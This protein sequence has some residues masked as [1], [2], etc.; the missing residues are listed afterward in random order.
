MSID[1]NPRAPHV[2]VLSAPGINLI[3]YNTFGFD[4][5]FRIVRYQALVMWQILELV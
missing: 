3:A 4:H 2:Y 1:A 5:L